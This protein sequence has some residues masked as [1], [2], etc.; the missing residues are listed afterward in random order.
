MDE[1]RIAQPAHETATREQRALRLYRERGDEIRHLYGS[2]YRVPAQDGERVY[3]VEYGARE[4]CSCADH[5]Y[6][7]ETCV[8]LYALGIAV[9]KGRLVH[10]EVA[11]G[12]PFVAAGR[13]CACT[14]GF[15]YIGHL[16]EDPE[17]GEEAE[18]IQRVPC[19][20]CNR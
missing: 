10:P 13:P 20:R 8:H 7:N 16:V 6:R 11:A 19:K 4:Y 1:V 17:T 5:R 2:T 15:V 3:G 9:A 14:D 12:D 18:I